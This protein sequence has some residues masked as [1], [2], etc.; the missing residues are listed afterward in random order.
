MNAN[1]MNIQTSKEIKFYLYIDI[2]FA[3]EEKNSLCKKILP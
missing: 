3:K 1:I 2:R